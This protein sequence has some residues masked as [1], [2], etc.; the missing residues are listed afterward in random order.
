MFIKY[1]IEAVPLSFLFYTSVHC[2]HLGRSWSAMFMEV[3]YLPFVRN[4]E[5]SKVFE[6]NFVSW[7]ASLLQLHG[8]PLMTCSIWSGPGLSINTVM[9]VAIGTAFSG[10]GFPTQVPSDV[11]M[12]TKWCIHTQWLP[13]SRPVHIG[14]N[15]TTLWCACPLL[16][17]KELPLPHMAVHHADR[18]HCEKVLNK[19][20]SASVHRMCRTKRQL[21]QHYSKLLGTAVM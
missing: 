1:L 20:A 21:T 9:A 13:R 15:F 8:Y 18:H 6:L 3:C 2:K 16:W 5:G 17:R 14:R 19:T 10:D 11:T 4:C 12:R 7:Q